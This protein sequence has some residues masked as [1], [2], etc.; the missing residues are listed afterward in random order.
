MNGDVPMPCS[1]RRNPMQVIRRY[2]PEDMPLHDTLLFGRVDPA[3]VEDDLRNCDVVRIAAGELLLAPGE[4]NSCLYL[5][6]RGT[7]RVQLQPASQLL[8]M[9]GPGECAGEMSVLEHREPS[10]L[11]W[12]EQDCELLVIPCAT[13]WALIGKSHEVAINL[14]T[15]MCGRLRHTNQTIGQVIEHCRQFRQAS[16]VDALTGLYNRYWLRETFERLVERQSREGA[17]LSV[18]MAD[19]DH[20]KQINDSHGHLAGDRVLQAIGATLLAHLRPRDQA[21]R[22]GGE[23]LL[24]ILPDVGRD[25]A[26]EVAE[27]LREQISR[28]EVGTFDGGTIQLTVSLG[29]A[30]LGPDDLAETLLQRVDEALYRAKQRRDCVCC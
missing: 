3:A 6:I 27:R 24:V 17:R 30:E 4:E 2:L 18:L 8:A 19:I 21:V 11:V 7:L 14:L 23:E 28:M 29:V 25:E 12:A 15:I 9:L 13:L 1:D 5:V 16:R 26:L 10:A 22:Y 20:F